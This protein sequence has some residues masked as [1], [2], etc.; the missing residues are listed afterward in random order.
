M[1]LCE[2]SSPQKHTTKASDGF[3]NHSNLL[4]TVEPR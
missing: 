2:P 1:E 4:T 3:H